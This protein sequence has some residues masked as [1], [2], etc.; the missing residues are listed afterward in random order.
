MIRTVPLSIIRSSFTEELF[1][2]CRVRCQNKFVKLLHLVG[3][4]IMKFVTM[5]GHT[6][7]NKIWEFALSFSMQFTK[8]DRPRRFYFW[9]LLDLYFKTF[10]QL[11]GFLLT[12]EKWQ[13]Y[14]NSFWIYSFAWGL[15]H[16]Y[17]KS[18][19]IFPDGLRKV[20]NILG[21]FPW[22]FCQPF[23]NKML[24]RIQ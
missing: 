21:H 1:E 8:K 16:V 19:S 9:F 3:F 11:L 15:W 22:T 6:N 10:S 23:K 18:I 2:I 13:C 12:N 5:D 24:E 17:N 7:V 14:R 20:R 4:I